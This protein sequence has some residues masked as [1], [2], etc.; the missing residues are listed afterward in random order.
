VPD[1]SNPVARPREWSYRSTGSPAPRGPV[2]AARRHEHP[3]VV[4][5]GGVLPAEWSVRRSLSYHPGI[6]YILSFFAA[7]ASNTAVPPP[8]RHLLHVGVLLADFPDVLHPPAVPRGL[9]LRYRLPRMDESTRDGPICAIAIP[10]G[11]PGA[12]LSSLHRGHR[13]RHNND[14]PPVQDLA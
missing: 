9:K 6:S 13:R 10:I 11:G 2:F 5:G 8:T 3:R 4:P 14:P 12:G 1:R 7:Q